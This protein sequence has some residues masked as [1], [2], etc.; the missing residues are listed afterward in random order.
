M[1][2]LLA[3]SI[4]HTMVINVVSGRRL[5]ER[6]RPKPLKARVLTALRLLVTAR[7]LNWQ[8]RRFCLVD[9]PSI[10]TL[11]WVDLSIILGKL[12]TDIVA[13]ISDRAL[14]EVVQ[15][16]LGLKPNIDF[17]ANYHPNMNGVHKILAGI[18]IGH[19]TRLVKTVYDELET[20]PLP[21]A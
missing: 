1:A 7:T 9:V 20:R 12:S 14:I 10:D 13:H 3:E 16:D 15:I 4:A 21:A 18:T 19:L 6:F 8:N 5:P 2:K 11:T 17:D